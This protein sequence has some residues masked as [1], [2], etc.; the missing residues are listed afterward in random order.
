MTF[1]AK[2]KDPQYAQFQAYPWPEAGS[3][4]RFLVRNPGR[5]SSY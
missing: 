3:V 2:G 4:L 5:S 1:V